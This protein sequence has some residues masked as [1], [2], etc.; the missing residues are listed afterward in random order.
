MDQQQT[1][2]YLGE[3]CLI[4]LNKI[5]PD[6]PNYNQLRPIVVM[7]PLFKFLEQRLAN[8]SLQDYTQIQIQV[9]RFLSRQMKIRAKKSEK[10]NIVFIDFSNGD[11]TVKRPKLCEIFKDKRI[12]NRLKLIL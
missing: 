11:N 1:S 2:L 9:S 4:Q 3:T 12:L 8:L 10:F 7:S 6:I 5:F